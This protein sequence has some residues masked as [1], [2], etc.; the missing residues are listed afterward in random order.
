MF[1]ST[2]SVVCQVRAEVWPQLMLVGETLKFPVTGE[3]ATVALATPALNRGTSFNLLERAQS[4]VFCAPFFPRSIT[5]FLPATTVTSPDQ[6]VF[7]CRVTVM[8]CT[9]TGRS[10]FWC[11]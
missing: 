7:P 1:A 3:T 11:Q 4:T 10:R 9:P 5:T 2:V 6:M 8:W